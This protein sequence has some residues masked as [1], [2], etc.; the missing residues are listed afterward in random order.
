MRNRAVLVLVCTMLLAGTVHAQT[1]EYRKAPGAIAELPFSEAV[2]VG[3]LLYLSGMIG[4]QPGTLNLVAG[5]ITAETRQTLENIKAAIERNGG[6]I[7]NTV[8]CLVMLADMAEW[9]KMN[10][11]Y[12]TFFPKNKPARSSFGASGLAMNARVEIECIVALE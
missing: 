10:E 9:A 4:V 12:T 8:K 1:P 5:G 11:V 3:N 7:D 6:S 2:R